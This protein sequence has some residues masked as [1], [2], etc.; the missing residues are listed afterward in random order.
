MATLVLERRFSAGDRVV[1]HAYAP[2]RFRLARGV[3][4]QV[5]QFTPPPGHKAYE[6]RWIIDGE[7]VYQWHDERELSPLMEEA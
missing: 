5:R 4:T 3:V 2:R 7:M 6:V 1:G